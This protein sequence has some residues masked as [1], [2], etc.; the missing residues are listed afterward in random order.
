[1]KKFIL[2]S[3]VLMLLAVSVKGYCA[4]NMPGAPVYGVQKNVSTSNP[5]DKYLKKGKTTV[6]N[7][8]PIKNN[9]PNL[10][11]LTNINGSGNAQMDSL[12]LK[13]LKEAENRNNSGMKTYAVKLMELGVTSICQP[14]II[15][16]RT[17]Q[18]PPIKIQ[19]NGM[20]KSGSLCALTCYEYEGTTYDVGYCK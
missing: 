2:F 18:C 5:S 6:N 8:V 11:E 1:M 12:A 9:L 4:T 7:N 19:V 14:Q 13:M 3:V 17:P 10:E 15:A 16:K 20:T